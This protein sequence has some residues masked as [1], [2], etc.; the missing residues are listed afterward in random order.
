MA[1]YVKV[2][3][4]GTIQFNFI[5]P[6]GRTTRLKIH[7]ARFESREKAQ[8]FIDANAPDNPEFEWKVA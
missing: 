6:G 8:A 5:A 4:R 1:I 7:A 2:R 3:E